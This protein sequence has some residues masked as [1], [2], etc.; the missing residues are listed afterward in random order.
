MTTQSFS[1]KR[2]NAYREI[3]DKSEYDKFEVIHNINITISVDIIVSLLCMGIIF[4][5]DFVIYQVAKGK[6]I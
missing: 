1:K 5:V 3:N 6:W 4:Y 2:Y